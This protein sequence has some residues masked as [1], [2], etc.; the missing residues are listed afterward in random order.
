MSNETINTTK[1]T[2]SR[3]MTF[4]DSISNIIPALIKLQSTVKGLVKDAKGHGYD[5]IT[6][7]QILAIARPELTAN[8][9]FMTQNV[10]GSMADDNNVAGCQTMIFHSSGEWVCS[11]IL[12][13]KPVGIGKNSNVGPRDLGAAITYAKRYQLSAIIGL[14]AEV[15]TDGILDSM[16]AWGQ[17]RT[18][19]QM[20]EIKK[21][22]KE[23][24]VKGSAMKEIAKE[25]IGSVKASGEYTTK[26]ADAIINHL[27]EL[28]N[29]DGEE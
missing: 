15:D 4:S 10:V 16:V 27:K 5:Y 7:D 13:I 1:G 9:L 18:D 19:E 11:G 23:K 29:E 25:V 28:S 24:G 21:L 17:I 12:E 2:G 3:E 8:G 6:L 14:S 20:E 22:M 26:D